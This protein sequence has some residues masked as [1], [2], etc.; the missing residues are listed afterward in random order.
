MTERLKKE[1]SEQDISYIFLNNFKK[2]SL[3]TENT[4]LNR[5]YITINFFNNGQWDVHPDSTYHFFRLIKIL[6]GFK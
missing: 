3:S 1:I 2:I 4:I 5:L 6:L